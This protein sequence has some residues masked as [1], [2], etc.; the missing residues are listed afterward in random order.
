MTVTSG[1]FN[2]IN[3]DRKYDALQMGE[4]FDGLI[5]DGV[6]ETIYNKFKVSA[7]S[8]FAVQVDTGRGWFQ[9]TWIKND[10]LKIVYLDDPE[11]MYDRI[12]AV[13]IQ[14]DHSDAGR[15]DTI[16]VVKGVGSNNPSRPTLKKGEGNIYQYPLAYVKVKSN[17]TGITAA[18]ITNAIGTSECPFVTGVVEVMNIDMF[19][20]Q[21]GAEW[22]YWLMEHENQF[23]YEFKSWFSSLKTILE[24]DTAAELTNL[25]LEMQEMINTL[26]SKGY[27][28]R[29]I[30][31][32]TYDP[33][34]DANG[35]EI[36]GTLT[37]TRDGY[38]GSS[39]S[40]YPDISGVGASCS[41]TAMT[42][43]DIDNIW[44]GVI[45]EEGDIE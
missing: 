9:H 3:H 38:S 4:L 23:T 28:L 15:T 14:V 26:A 13:V 39:S 33:I 27:I 44:N 40:N 43:A 7:N 25:F 2:S 11:A 1:F 18:D 36:E 32:I 24:G 10:G 37:F 35:N 20:E 5:N 6:Y 42:D 34:L 45:F 22:N 17:A 16:T 30:Q 21:W 8:G 31:D 41:C 29:P 19:I 12:D